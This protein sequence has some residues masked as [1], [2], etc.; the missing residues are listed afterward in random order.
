MADNQATTH[1]QSGPEWP[2]GRDAQL[3]LLMAHSWR[4]E[5]EQAVDRVKKSVSRAELDRWFRKQWYIAEARRKKE[6]QVDD[7]QVRRR[8]TGAHGGDRKARIKPKDE[9]PV[10]S[11]ARPAW[12]DTV[13]RGPALEAVQE[14]AE[15]ARILGFRE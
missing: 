9:R 10:G 4:L 15:A 8:Q 1:P 3:A 2:Y 11:S 12:A 5:I 6:G 13:L 14:R 7:R